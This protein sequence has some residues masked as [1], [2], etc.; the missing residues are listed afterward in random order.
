MISG[1]YFGEIEIIFNK[2][3]Y[4]DCIAETDC[5]IFQ[6]SNFNYI[7]V[8]K[9]QFPHIHKKLKKIAMERYKKN[10]ESIK[11]V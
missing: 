1:S 6:L 7:T 3:R 5:E 10:K 4:F 11:A 2:K 9:Q 8:V